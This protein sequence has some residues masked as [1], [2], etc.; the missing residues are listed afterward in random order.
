MRFKLSRT[1]TTCGTARGTL[2]CTSKAVLPAFRHILSRKALRT[3]AAHPNTFLTST[4]LRK[5]KAPCAA[6]RD[7][8]TRIAAASADLATPLEQ[9]QDWLEDNGGSANALNLAYKACRAA[10]KI[11]Q[12][13]VC[14]PA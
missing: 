12:D 11:Q 9:L 7:F 13:E 14:H 4:S 5:G 2:P 1:E 3:R 6:R 8:A 10:R